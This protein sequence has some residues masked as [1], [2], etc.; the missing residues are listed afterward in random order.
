ME[1]E[2]ELFL[3][4]KRFVKNVSEHT[5]E[6]YKYGFKA[7][8]KHSKVKSFAEL[9]K[10]ELVSLVASMR[11]SGLSPECTDAYIRGINPFLTWAFENG[12]TD[13]HLKIKRQ[14]LEQKVINTF[15]DAQVKAIIS[16]KPKDKYERRFHCLLLTL[17]DTGIRINEALTL[18]R[19]KLDF[20][21]LLMTV[22]GKGNKQRI[23]PF[24]VELR[25]VLYKHAQSHNYDLV[26]CTRHGCKLNRNN[27]RREF[28]RL[29]EKLGIK[30]HAGSFH[31]FRR[32]FATNYIRQS[33]NTFMLQRLL[34]HESQAMTGKYVK[35]VTED[36]SKEQNRTSILNR[37]R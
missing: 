14:K 23:I 28:N 25:K 19:N 26:F 22:S 29:I 20:D 30:G 34:G 6:F 9:N 27:M 8:Q 37:L 7:L 3:R 35:L 33:G 11:E 18:K 5:I 24:S 1:K 10:I 12:L 2:F 16:Y 31:A 15:T 4:E 32:F 36:L 13:E 17:L 21:N